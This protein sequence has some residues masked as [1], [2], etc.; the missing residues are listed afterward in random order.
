[1]ERY[2]GS[3]LNAAIKQHDCLYGND[4]KELEKRLLADI[5]ESMG[6]SSN[7]LVWIEDT[8]TYEEVRQLRAKRNGCRW[9]KMLFKG[10]A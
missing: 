7:A 5:Y 2:R 6:E 9:E 3:W 1:M 4:I 8:T 10:V